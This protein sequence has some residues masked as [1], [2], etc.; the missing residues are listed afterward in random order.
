M[1]LSI[2]VPDVVGSFYLPSFEMHKG[3]MFI[4]TYRLIFHPYMKLKKGK[5]G[6]TPKSP[7]T[8]AESDAETSGEQEMIEGPLGR[9]DMQIPML[10]IEKILE[11]GPRTISMTL[12]DKMVV[13]MM[14]NSGKTM[15]S[16][17]E[18]VRQHCTPTR[19]DEV[20]AFR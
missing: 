19:S 5:K 4:T 1:E 2:R 8:P 6:K 20:F 17:L 11:T 12:K 16:F 3:R 18:E 10:K 9:T 7:R 13:N 15:D 14:F